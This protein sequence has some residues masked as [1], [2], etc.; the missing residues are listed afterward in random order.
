MFGPREDKALS[1]VWDNIYQERA[2]NL[3]RRFPGWY[4]GVIVETNDPLNMRRVRVKIPEFHNNGVK[5]EEVMWAT[6]A[7]WMGGKMAGCWTNFMI[8]DV[9]YVTLEKQHAYGPICVAAA[10]PTRDRYYSLWSTYTKPAPPI[11]KDGKPLASPDDHL[12]E[13]LP[14]DNRPMSTGMNDR[15][16]HFFVMSSVGFFPKNHQVSPASAGTDAL[17]KK[18]YEASKKPPTINEPDVKFFAMGTKYGNYQILA[19]QGYKW[20]E[21]FKGDFD[22]DEEFEVKRYKYLISQFNEGQPK[23][24]DQR[25]NEWRTRAGHKFEMRDVGWQMSRAG[26]YGDPKQI[27][28]SRGK[29]ERWVKLRTKGGHLI[30]AIDVGFDP[31]N[32]KRYKTLNKTE[33]GDETDGEKELGTNEGDDARMVRIV[34]RHGN[35]IVFDDR[36]SSPTD[37]G[38]SDTPN[39]NGVMMRSRRGHQLQFS[40]KPDLNHTMMVSAGDQ[41]FEQNDKF[42]YTLITTAQANGIHVPE[43]SDPLKTKPRWVTRTGQSND[44]EFNTYHFKLDQL[45]DYI[46]M[47]TPEGAGFEARGSRAP[48]GSWLE[49]RDQENRALWMSKKDNWLVLRDK[50]GGKFILLDDNDDVVLIRNEVG[51]IQIRA[52][53]KIEIKCEEGN[54]CLEAPK[55]EIGLRAKKVAVE[56][57]GAQHVFDAIGFGS[58]KKVQGLELLQSPRGAVPCKVDDKNIERKK[59][60]DDDKERGCDEFKP[61]KGQVP[62]SVVNSAPG[63]GGSSSSPPV[64]SSDPRAQLPAPSPNQP[65]QTVN[66]P[67]QPTIEEDPIEQVNNGGGGVLWYGLSAKFLDE[68]KSLG[69]SLAS[70]TN[71]NNL[72]GRLSASAIPLAKSLTYAEGKYQAILMQQRYGDVALVIR[73]R[74]LP[75][76]DLLEPDEVNVELV[77][78][79]GSIPF[80]GCLEVYEIGE[81]G[82][83]AIPLYPDVD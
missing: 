39:G 4:R 55:G 76:P 2:S 77:N 8:D 48:C 36:G 80:D 38:S 46:R 35:Q 27:A 58:T 14:Q 62:D 13:Y 28:N 49:M 60:E 71:I 9:V 24:R 47:K 75:D 41:V 52:K 5:A 66:D 37:A 29:D 78:Y 22:A 74:N 40:D 50:G 69:L 1:Q 44:P 34:T 19:D 83:V 25:R 31:V 42:K 3:F 57:N 21:E 43:G 81:N 11:S 10:D 23:E 56:T 79:R 51:K 73:V 61:Q 53:D 68:V 6:P 33:I 30:E 15:Y 72:P 59:P 45:N 16:G 20:D 82:L 26:E 70:L 18:D 65:V 67:P 63:G 54:I 17:A 12:K 7:P 32:D 64:S